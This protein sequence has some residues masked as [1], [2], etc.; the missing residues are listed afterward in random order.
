MWFFFPLHEEVRKSQS[1][2]QYLN[3]H[4]VTIGTFTQSGQFFDDQNGLLSKKKNA[5]CS[6]RETF[7]ALSFYHVDVAQ[8]FSEFAQLYFNRFINDRTKLNQKTPVVLFTRMGSLILGFFFLSNSKW[9]T[10]WLTD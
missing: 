2:V 8:I 9:K 5:L 1:F 6:K 3:C 10:D 4:R 7:H